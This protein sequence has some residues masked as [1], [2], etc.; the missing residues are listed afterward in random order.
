M[1]YGYYSGAY[2]GRDVG[3]VVTTVASTGGTGTCTV[4][5]NSGYGFG[6]GTAVL[7]SGAG[8]CAAPGG[9]N[10][11]SDRFLFEPTVGFVQTL[12][13]NPNY[14]D[15]KII[16]QYS[17]VSRTPW[18]VSPGT[19]ATAHTSMGYIDLRYDLP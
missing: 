7:A 19:P 1:F 16:T 9:S 6:P 5:T 17:Y 10:N 14:G 18:F 11:S 8:T 2:F 13:K 4:T 12:W 3:T 15:L